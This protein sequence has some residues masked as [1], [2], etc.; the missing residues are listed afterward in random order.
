MKVIIDL[1][2]VGAPE[3]PSVLLAGLLAPP[4]PKQF[5]HIMKA[6]GLSASDRICGVRAVDVAIRSDLL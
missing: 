5:D 2:P 3:L 1:A 4:C 6:G